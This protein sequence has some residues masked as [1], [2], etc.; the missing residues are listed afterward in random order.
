MR[1]L[2]SHVFFAGG[3]GH[4][5]GGHGGGHSGP[6]DPK[7]HVEDSDV[8]HLELGDWHWSPDVK[9]LEGWEHF[10]SFEMPG[11]FVDFFKISEPTF[12]LS[13][14]TSLAVLFMWISAALLLGLVLKVAADRR[15][16]PDKPP[17]GFANALEAMVLFVRDE[18][19]YPN[20]GHKSGRVLLPYFLT[21][22]FFI[23][24]MN[25]IGMLPFSFTPTNQISLTFAAALTAWVLMFFGGFIAHGPKFAV[26]VVP[27]KMEMNL[28]LPIMIIVW[29]I[30][31]ILELVLGMVIKSFA[32][33]MRLKANMTAGHL[34]IFTLLLLPFQKESWGMGIMGMALSLLIMIIE[35]LV[36]VLQAYV[37]TLLTAIFVGHSVNTEEHH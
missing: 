34:V 36:C 21:I 25:F 5:E 33:M 1:D 35:C 7:S 26:T 28:L 15:R 3:H 8:W 23:L 16:N 4:E 37:F 19:V 11:W 14:H 20:C 13:A 17:R 18:I 12:H 6:F 10:A 30:L 31:W 22:F 27:I 2:L 32:L 24:T 9:W 29:V